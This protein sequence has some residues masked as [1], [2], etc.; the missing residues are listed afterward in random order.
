MT[1]PSGTPSADTTALLELRGVSKHFADGDVDALVDVNLSIM[2]AEFIAIVGPSGGGKSTLLNMLGALDEPTQGEV[3]FEGKRLAEYPSMD[4][5]RAHKIGFIFQSYRLLPNLTAQEN[6]Q[7]TMF[8][9]HPNVSQRR[10]EAIRLLERVGLGDRVN[11]RADKLS[12]GQ[13]QRVA[14]ARAIAGNPPL[15]L[16]DEP[17][18]ALDTERGDEVMDLLDE[19]RQEE[20]ATLVVV[21]HDERVAERADRVVYICDG[22]LRTV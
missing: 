5:F 12:I 15:I 2:S 8:D 18:G 6:V 1:D 16:A 11:H 10:A 13:R 14:I 9:T 21:T 20:G 22:R 7:L 3:W 4:Q 19:L 17:T